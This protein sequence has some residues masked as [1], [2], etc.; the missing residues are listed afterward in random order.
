[1]TQSLSTIPL[2][3][4]CPSRTSELA[5][6]ETLMGLFHWY[7]YFRRLPSR[8]PLMGTI[9]LPSNVGGKL[10]KLKGWTWFVRTQVGKQL[11]GGWP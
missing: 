9:R 7:R 2:V 8:W 3:M 11:K 1:M 4:S 10:E 5:V 6:L